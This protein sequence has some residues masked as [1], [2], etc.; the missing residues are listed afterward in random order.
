MFTH[1]FLFFRSVFL[2]STACNDYT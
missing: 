1:K 2:A